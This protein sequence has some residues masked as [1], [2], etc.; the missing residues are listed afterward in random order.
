M[1]RRDQKRPR[2][3]DLI[4][5]SA[6]LDDLGQRILAVELANPGAS[7]TE[8]R[9]L[10]SDRPGRKT[11]DARRRSA[12]YRRAL[13]DARKPAL[14]LLADA[15]VS[16]VKK[17]VGFLEHP[18]PRIALGAAK[19]L[20]GGTLEYRRQALAQ[21]LAREQIKSPPVKHIVEVRYGSSF[22]TAPNRGGVS[23]SR[24]ATGVISVLPRPPDELS[25]PPLPI[26]DQE[27]SD[28]SELLP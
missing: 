21:E 1:P 20:V 22:P 15:E 17:L 12:Q 11:I 4:D 9:S 25:A 5:P 13:A 14:Q 6:Q 8:I 23:E 28:S 26:D 24:S 3:S 19:A 16:A 27:D 18:D 2:N 7:S 10:L